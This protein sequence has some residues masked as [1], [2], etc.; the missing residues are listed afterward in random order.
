MFL[1]LTN[2]GAVCRF[3]RRAAIKGDSR[4]A[5][6]RQAADEA[7]R[8]AVKVAKLPQLLRKPFGDHTALGGTM[9][10]LTFGMTL[11]SS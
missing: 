6:G 1:L 11:S 8:T 4:P 5:I 9:K 3:A 7:R 2:I 10:H